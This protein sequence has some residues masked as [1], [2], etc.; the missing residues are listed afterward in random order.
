MSQHLPSKESIADIFRKKH[1]NGMNLLLD[2]L[3]N[4]VV[5]LEDINRIQVEYFKNPFREIT[6]FFTR[7][8]G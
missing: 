5:D 6:W 1:D 8:I 7:L 2:F 3:E 4:P